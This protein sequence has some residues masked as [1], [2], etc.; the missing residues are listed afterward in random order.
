[1]TSLAIRRARSEKQKDREGERER[2]MPRTPRKTR[3]GYSGLLLF[4]VERRFKGS[5]ITWETLPVQRNARADKQTRQVI[6]WLPGEA[7]SSP[8][9]LCSSPKL[10]YNSSVPVPA[11]A[12]DSNTSLT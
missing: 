5:V 1:M 11:L 4:L 2:K 10:A 7:W 9:N 3:T 12:S 8:A 6:K